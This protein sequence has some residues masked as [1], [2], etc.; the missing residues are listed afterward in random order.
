MKIKS[1]F[2]TNSSSTSYSL[3]GSSDVN[4]IKDILESILDIDIKISDDEWQTFEDEELIEEALDALENGGEGS[5]N[6]A[7]DGFYAY[8]ITENLGIMINGNHGVK[9]GVSVDD[10]FNKFTDH[11][12]KD[13]NQVVKDIIKEETGIDVPIEEISLDVGFWGC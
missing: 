6:A 13:L 9:V 7:D 5:F 1:D 2:V 12:I 4:S 11:K 8:K 10:M 3:I